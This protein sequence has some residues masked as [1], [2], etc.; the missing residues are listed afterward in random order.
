[1]RS[2][3]GVWPDNSCCYCN[4]QRRWLN[5]IGW[6]CSQKKQIGPEEE[7]DSIHIQRSSSA[8]TPW[9]PNHVLSMKTITHDPLFPNRGSRIHCRHATRPRTIRL[10]FPLP[11]FPLPIFCSFPLFV[12]PFSS[13][14]LFLFH[15]SSFLLFRFPLFPIPLS[16]SSYISSSPF[17]LPLFS[18]FPLFLFPFS[19]S[20][21][22]LFPSVPLPF[23]LFPSFPLPLFLLSSISLIVIVQSELELFSAHLLISVIIKMDRQRQRQRRRMRRARII[24]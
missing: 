22:V 24:A 1:M 10:S 21:Y 7:K 15:F 6:K 18:S 3:V 5:H 8:Q 13:S 23:L 16:S 9:K 17:P 20:T 4:T 19:S 11:L 2:C 12:F 14:P